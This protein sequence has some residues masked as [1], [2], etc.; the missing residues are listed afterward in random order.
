MLT[1]FN[2]LQWILIVSHKS[3]VHLDFHL[4]CCLQARLDTQSSFSHSTVP[5]GYQSQRLPSSLTNCPPSCSRVAP[6]ICCS[7]AAAASR[8]VLS[9]VFCTTSCI[10]LS[11]RRASAAVHA[12]SRHRVSSREPIWPLT[13]IRVD[14]PGAQ[15]EANWTT[16][17][18]LLVSNNACGRA[19]NTHQDPRARSATCVQDS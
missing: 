8:T 19:G 6:S 12:W 11:S 9:G 14:C 18:T 16:S 17:N 4:H 3:V 5:A 7:I 2:P 10:A 13:Q 15:Q 1:F